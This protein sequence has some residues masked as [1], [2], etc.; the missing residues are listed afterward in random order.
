M[1]ALEKADK[2]PS[3]GRDVSRSGG[4][5]YEM[6]IRYKNPPLSITHKRRVPKICAGMI[7]AGLLDIA[8]LC[9]TDIFFGGQRGRKVAAWQIPYCLRYNCSHHLLHQRNISKWDSGFHHK[10]L[11]L[12]ALWTMTALSTTSASSTSHLNLA[13]IGYGYPGIHLSAL[14]TVCSFDWTDY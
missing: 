8:D 4:R 1:D 3:G 5:E 11:D 10:F 2:R 13:R 6:F 14:Y 7:P 9:R 12:D